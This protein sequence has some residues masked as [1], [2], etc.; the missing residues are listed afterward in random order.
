MSTIL[1]KNFKPQSREIK[2]LGRDFNQIK[3]NLIDFAK[4]YYPK[5]YKDFSDASPGMMFIDMASYVGDVLSFYIDYQFKEG[6]IEFSEER[7]NVINLAKYLG[8]TTKPSKPSITT[9]DLYM[10]AP[11]KRNSDGTFEPDERYTLSI[12]EGM[13]VL[14]STGISFLTMDV[15]NFSL[16]SELSPRTD[17]VFSRNDVGEP[18][19]YL[20]KKS[21]QAYSGK[22]T[23]TSVTVNSDNPNLRIEL[24][25][26]NVIKI[27][28]VKDSDN[29]TWYQVDYLAQDLVQLP[30]ENN[31]YNFEKFSQFRSTVPNIIRFLRTNRRFTVEVDENNKTF[32]Q[33]GPSTDNI[34]EELL[35]PNSDSLGIGF[36]N[37]SKYNLTL[38]PTSFLN[39]NSYGLSPFNTTLE[40]TYVVGGGIQSNVN[41]GDITKVSKIEFSELQD[42]LPSEIALVN[43]IKTSLRVENPISAT[44][45]S[46]P[47]TIVEI[48]QNAMA[49]FAAQDRIVTKDDYIARVFS[50]PSE[51]G[52]IAK[53]YVTTENDLYTN[54]TSYIPG[55][56]DENN[57]II[58]D[59]QNQN[60]RKIN[61]DGINPNAVNLYVLTYDDNKKLKTINEALSYNLRNYLS[62]YRMLSDRVNIID[63][64]IVNIGINFT[65]LTY[66]NYNKKEVLNNCVET[67]KNFFNIDLWQ[68]SQPININQLELE[69]AKI[70]GVQSVANLEV[71]NITDSGYSI[72]EYDIPSAT[73]NK[74]IYPPIDPAIFEVKNPNIDIKGRVL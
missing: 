25:E 74:I 22:K 68:I 54:N 15:V 26:D 28:N 48:K 38:D 10:I 61:L 71:I 53:A 52:R 67:I 17:E 43:T 13:E 9:L 51:Y 35:V 58:V 45:G 2:Y 55:L 59:E 46:G 20:L 47:E 14:S 8:Y 11:S 70:E 39:S 3:Q 27:L 37:I 7:K 36:S 12:S 50:M 73:K 65:I 32:L 40:I 1:D 29:N 6:L 33:F 64:F 31:Q 16:K 41:V 24:T 56:I 66:S 44:G 21:V 19:F 23:T 69:I 18:E 63:A 30:V 4:Q 57:N 5:S 42:Y 34:E 49:N 60:F 62:K 72:C